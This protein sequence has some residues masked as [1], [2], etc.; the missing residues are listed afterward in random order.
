MCGTA[1][2]NAGRQLAQEHCARCDRLPP[3]RSSRYEADNAVGTRAAC[4]ADG[5]V[6]TKVYGK[7]FADIGNEGQPFHNPAFPTY[8]N[9]TCP[10]V[11][12]VQFQQNDFAGS[13]AKPSQQKQD[14]II[15]APT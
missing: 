12:I 13:K 3:G 1:G 4:G 2:P 9:L 10:P 8:H 6:V 11:N 5:T 15:T 7:C 14:C